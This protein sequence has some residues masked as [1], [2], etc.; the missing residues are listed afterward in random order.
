M[1]TNL[2]HRLWRG[3][4]LLQ[5]KASPQINLVWGF[6]MY[7]I[8]GWGLLCIPWFH[9]ESVSVLDNL[10]TSTSAISTTGLVTVSITGS[11]NLAGQII[12]LLLFQVGGI[13]YMTLT[14]YYLIFTTRRITSWHQR[15]IGT[16]FTMPRS[17]RVK[18][19]IKSVIFFTI[20]MEV[21]GAVGLYIGFYKTD[22]PTGQAI[23]YSIFHSVSAFCTAGFGL[24][25]NS[26]IPFQN[27]IWI[28]TVISVLAIAG[29]LG[30]I[31]I[32]DLWYRLRGKTDKLSFTT[33]VIGYGF[34]ILLGLGTLLTWLTEPGL[35]AQEHSLMKAF[36][37]A[38]TAMTTVG[39]S[40][41]PT[42]ELSHPVLLLVLFLMYVGAS[43][44]GTAGGM[45]ITTLTAMLSVIKSRLFGERRISFL[46]R[47]I[48]F[49]RLYVAT[50][51]FILYTSLIFL[52][53]F[54]LTYSEEA[55][56]ENILFEVA[57]AL[58]TVG[59]SAGLTG[60]LSMAGK[61]M[62][63]ILMF[64]GRVGVL[65]FGF[66]LLDFKTEKEKEEEE[67]KLE[68]EDLAV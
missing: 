43:P 28:N 31:V 24:D 55:T 16:A 10:F 7:T 42:A 41:I 15:L 13:G 63:I 47:E 49:N 37:Q 1:K 68:K 12:V 46:G 48:P 52:F 54:L 11:Y 39:F 51:T 34:L 65:T 38:M 17:I 50:S 14:T 57:S 33:K 40:T 56:F 58:G 61:I 60:N 3:Y 26:F 30:F 8:L 35:Y 45:K 29:S 25:D 44:S 4:R 27:N 32:T 18:D 2:L 19:F 5:R 23:W 62:I 9:K 59:L 22:M 64:I 36:F 66:A 67:E 20:I 21:L 6:F 53:A